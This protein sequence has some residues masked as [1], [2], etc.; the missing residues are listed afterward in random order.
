MAHTKLSPTAAQSER[1]FT[2]SAEFERELSD[3]A[4]KIISTLAVP[5]QRVWRDHCKKSGLPLWF[6]MLKGGFGFA[7]HLNDVDDAPMPELERATE[8]MM[9]KRQLKL[10][11][12]RMASG[13]RVE[14]CS[15]R[16]HRFEHHVEDTMRQFEW[17][18]KNRPLRRGI[19]ARVK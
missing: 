7:H 14:Y 12:M 11:R 16:V 3:A 4:E 1:G 15:I 2:Y 9:S 18:A 8:R 5:W 17:F 13:R 10:A 6:V 19:R